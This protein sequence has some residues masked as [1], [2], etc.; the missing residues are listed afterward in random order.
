MRKLIIISA[1][2]FGTIITC[3][4]Q[5]VNDTLY[6]NSNWEECQKGRHTYYRVIKP[7]SNGY[8]YLTDYWKNGQKQMTGK[9]SSLEP[10]KRVGQFK[11]FYSDGT[12]RQIINYDNDKVIGK[13]KLFK[14]TGELDI[15]YCDKID[16]LDNSDEMLK[17]TIDFRKYI[18]DNIRYPR[19]ARRKGIQGTVYTRFFINPKGKIERLSILRGVNEDLDSEAKRVVLSG[20]SFISPIYK[21]EKTYLEIIFPIAFRVQ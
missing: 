8:Y 4:G 2:I 11:W 3:K 18:S 20:Y 1:L 17:K 10:E 6:F 12:I 14:R 9:Y 16:S 21:G 7:N 19:K 15:E 5:E 13:I